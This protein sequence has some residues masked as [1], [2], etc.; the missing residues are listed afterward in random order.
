MRKKSQTILITLL[1]IA[2]FGAG[3]SAQKSRACGE[4]P[5]VSALFI[6]IS[7]QKHHDARYGQ[8]DDEE[9]I[10]WAEYRTGAGKNYKKPKIHDENIVLVAQRPVKEM[11]KLKLFR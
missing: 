7:A 11:R 6:C 8:R 5:Q 4:N 10:F 9:H 2:C 1:C 3:I